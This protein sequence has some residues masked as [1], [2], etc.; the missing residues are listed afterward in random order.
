MIVSL[1]AEQ[2]HATVMARPFWRCAAPLP[3]GAGCGLS[4]AKSGSTNMRSGQ[5]MKSPLPPSPSQSCC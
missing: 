4:E 5:S 1:R 3:L 2:R